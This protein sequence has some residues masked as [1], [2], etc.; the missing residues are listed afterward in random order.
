MIGYR[1]FYSYVKAAKIIAICAVS[2]THGA[3]RDDLRNPANAIAETIGI[4]YTEY[5]LQKFSTAMRKLKCKY[6]TNWVIEIF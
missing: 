1:K 2:S 5:V 6:W 4:Q 3:D